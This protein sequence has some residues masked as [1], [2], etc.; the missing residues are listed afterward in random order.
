[1]IERI[2]IE[3]LEVHARVGVSENE[4]AHPQRLLINLTFWPKHNELAG[5]DLTQAVDYAAVTAR[6]K[7]LA[8]TSACKLI[9]TLAEKIAAALMQDFPLRKV[10]IEVRKFVLPDTQFVS[11]NCLRQDRDA[12][13]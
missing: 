9:E 11:V 6:A 3:Q 1:M 13:P 8:E 10:S 2:H 4:R 7:K 12:S 5:D